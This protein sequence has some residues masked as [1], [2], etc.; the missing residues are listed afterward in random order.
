MQPIVDWI[1][2]AR[3]RQEELERLTFQQATMQSDRWHAQACYIEPETKGRYRENKVLYTFPDG[4][5][6]VE[7]TNVHD[8]QIE[9]TLMQNCMRHGTYDNALR[10]GTSRF[11][12][13]RDPYNKP[14]VAIE[15]TKYGHLRQVYGKQ[16]Q[17]PDPKYKNYIWAWLRHEAKSLT[18]VS[19]LYHSMVRTDEDMRQYF[20]LIHDSPD[21]LITAISQLINTKADEEYWRAKKR[22]NYDVFIQALEYRI[23]QSKS[24]HKIYRAIITKNY[25]N[26]DNLLQ[27]FITANLTPDYER[28]I[29]ST[30]ISILTA[31]I[32]KHKLNEYITVL[33]QAM[34]RSENP[35]WIER[36][37]ECVPLSDYVLLRSRANAIREGWMY[38]D[39]QMRR[40]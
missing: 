17:D 32:S 27:G 3:P 16:N 33:Q 22:F 39:E 1:V 9:G 15:L 23:I 11:L 8:L 30:G 34:L 38:Q 4:W 6:I 37:V 20:A 28:I 26:I 19:D 7:I 2:G 24:A 14:H 40:K 12:S 13:L 29:L 36:F 21:Q 25:H 18:D 31:N 35:E 10:R 5:K